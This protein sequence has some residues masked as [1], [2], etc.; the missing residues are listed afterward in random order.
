[1]KKERDT[2]YLSSQLGLGIPVRD[3]NLNSIG[4]IGIDTVGIGTMGIVP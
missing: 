3:G 4:N 2:P 1:M